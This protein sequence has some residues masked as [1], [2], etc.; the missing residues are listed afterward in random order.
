MHTI[1]IL[2]VNKYGDFSYKRTINIED[3]IYSHT[4]GTHGIDI[5]HKTNGRLLE[6]YTKEFYEMGIDEYSDQPDIIKM[7]FLSNYITIEDY[8]KLVA[9]RTKLPNGITIFKL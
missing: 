4:S 3:Y 5:K 2:K 8:N 9:S 6:L 7:V 1:N